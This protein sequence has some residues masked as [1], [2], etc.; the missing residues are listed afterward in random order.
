M[1]TKY[2]LIKSAHKLKKFLK[3]GEE[4]GGRKKEKGK[5]TKTSALP[6]QSLI[7]ILSRPNLA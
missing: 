2:V 5:P 6:S 3:K 1:K 7:Q 4:G